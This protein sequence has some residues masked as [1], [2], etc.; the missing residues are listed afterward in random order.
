MKAWCGTILVAAMAASG[1]STG[2]AKFIGGDSDYR[3][4]ASSG[5][6]GAVGFDSLDGFW[7]YAML[8]LD[9]NPIYKANDGI[10]AGA[11]QWPAIWQDPGL[12]FFI[13]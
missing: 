9:S 3:F 2:K 11:R 4:Y 8:D 1:C 10:T 12:F 5:A 7:Q 13:R 6:I